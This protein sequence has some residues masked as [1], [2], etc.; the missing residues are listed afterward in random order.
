MTKQHAR[1]ADAFDLLPSDGPQLVLTEAGDIIGRAPA[2]VQ[3]DSD[4]LRFF[5]SLADDLGPAHRPL[6]AVVDLGELLEDAQGRLTVFQMAVLLGL[7]RGAADLH[8]GDDGAVIVPYGMKAEDQA[9]LVATCGTNRP[10]MADLYA[11]LVAP[12]LRSPADGLGL[13]H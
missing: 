9:R 5:L 13:A 12:R 3:A 2:H 8:G 4:E 7:F 6:Q 10:R 11:A 1:P